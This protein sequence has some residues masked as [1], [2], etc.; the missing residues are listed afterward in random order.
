M[1]SDFT[2]GYNKIPQRRETVVGQSIWK[3]FGGQGY[4]M[5]AGGTKAE[6]Q[7][8][9]KRWGGGRIIKLTSKQQE[10]WAVGK[11]SWGLFVRS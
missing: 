10:V 8:L 1:R 9:Q 6:M 11:P 2:D 5:K 4:K 3:V 7:R